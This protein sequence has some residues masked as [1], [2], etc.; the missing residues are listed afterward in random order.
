MADGLHHQKGPFDSSIY[1][2]RKDN[3]NIVANPKI[4]LVHSDSNLVALDNQSRD[5]WKELEKLTTL[6]K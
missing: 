3:Y 6:V 4:L 2:C 5:Y 1:E